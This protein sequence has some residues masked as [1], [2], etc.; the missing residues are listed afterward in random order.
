MQRWYIEDERLGR[1]ASTDRSDDERVE[2]SPQG[3]VELMDLTEFDP[4]VHGRMVA[5]LFRQ[6]LHATIPFVERR[7][8]GM[9][10]IIVAPTDDI[11]TADRHPVVFLLDRD[12]LRLIGETDACSRALDA[13]AGEG[14]AT[15]SAASVLCELIR[16]SVRDHP[17]QLSGVRHDFEIIE[18]RLLNGS[19]R[20]DRCR[21]RVDSRRLLGLDTLYQG[22]SDVASELAESAGS[23]V[24]DGDR[25]R[26]KALERH[27]DRL[28]T[29]LE[30]LRD[31]S[32]QLNSLYQEAIDTRQNS[33]M[34][35]LT[36]IA[37][38]FMPLTFITGW[39]GMNFP[40]MAMMSQPWGYALV[41]VV[42]L[43]IA[44]AEVLFFRR[45]GWLH[46]AGEIRPHR[47]AR[48]AGGHRR[49]GF[50]RGDRARRR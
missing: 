29:R 21:M 37:T 24:P 4:Q 41:V 18:E 11:G 46:F 34:Q 2:R 30:S 50:E 26:F 25:L 14:F 17:A 28:T 16:L 49:D 40:N 15:P 23:A 12:R 5:E 10:G 22:L 43:A 6:L 39:Y 3:N 31:Y 7:A 19:T 45:R 44:A 38:I 20:I 35:W 36:V 48:G 42:C 8:S 13:I 27:L 32:L 1:T 33:V 47:R 9:A